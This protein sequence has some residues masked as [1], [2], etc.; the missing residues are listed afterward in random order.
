[1]Y[2]GSGHGHSSSSF[3]ASKLQN[4]FTTLLLA[5]FVFVSVSAFAQ[6][7]IE[8]AVG[9]TVYDQ[10]DAVVAGATVVVHNNGTNAEFKQTTN[11]S[12]YFRVT[13]LT[14]TTYTVTVTAPGFSSYKAQAVTVEV[15]RVTE[16]SPKLGV[17][18]TAEQIVVTGEAP[19]VN[20][21]SA[22]FA[23]VLNS[24]AI[25]NLP[26]NGGRWSDFA[27][28]TPGVNNNV[29]GFGLLNVRGISSLM[30]NNTIDG[31]NNNQAFFSEER[32]RT[33]AG[34]STPKVAVQEFQVNTSNYSAEYGRAAGGVINTVTKS[35]TNDIHGEA[36]F[37]YRDNA[38]GSTNPFVTLTAQNSSGA[39]VTT[40]Y[41]PS[42]IRRISG[43]GIGGAIIKD[44]LF[45][46]F[47]YDWFYRNF[48]GTGSASNPGAFFAAPSTA[49]IALLA[50]KLGVT[51]AQAQVDYTNGLNGLNS[52][53]GPVPRTGE[54]YIWFPKVD[55]VINDKN[56]ASFSVNRMRWASPAGIQTQAVNFYG[57][58]SFGSD[59][60]KDTWGIAN[61]NTVITSN[62]SNQF[63]FQYGLDFEYEYAQN[64]STYEQN[65]LVTPPGY[66]NPLGLPPQVTITNGF[67]FGVQTFLQRPQYPSEYIQQ[68]ADTVSWLKGKHSFK[69]GVDINHSLDQTQNLRTQYGSYSYAN[70]NS[71]QTAL[72][73]YFTDLYMHN[74]CGTKAHPAPCYSGTYQQAF[75]PAGLQFSTN[76]L[77]FFAEDTWKT[78]PRLTLTLGLRYEYEMMPSTPLA[79]SAVPATSQLPND[80]NNW[81]PRF[82]FAYD[83]FGDGNTSL[84]GGFGMYYG[85]IINSTIYSALIS[86]GNP[87]GQLTYFYPASA[88]PVFPQIL[89]APS[90]NVSP[91]MVYFNHGFQNPLVYE[92]DLS[93]QHE[94]G[95]GYVFSLN[96]LGSMGRELPDFVDTNLPTPTTITYTV[97]SASGQG[98]L[99]PGSQITSLFYTGARPNTSYGAMTDIFSGVNSSYN[100]LAAVLNKRFNNGVQFN[101]NYTW[102]HALDY[103]QN[104]TTGSDTNDLLVPNCMRCEYGNSNFDVRQR[105]IVS[106]VYDLP[107][108]VNGWAG[109]LAN[110]WELA[111]IY[112]AQS[113]LPYSLVT[114]GTPSCPAGFN[115]CGIGLTSAVSGVGSGIN[116]SGGASRIL[117]TGR[118]TFRYPRT[119]VVDLRIS[120][121]IPIKERYQLQIL[122]EAF[123]LANHVNVTGV[124]NLGYSIGTTAGVPT[125]T[126]NS[127][128][129]AVTSANSNFAYSTRNIQIG[130]KFTF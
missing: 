17:A 3:S 61:L 100:A 50:S 71:T 82:G 21:T 25:E 126:Y 24:V 94:F 13:G 88:G 81:G 64:P 112:Q 7:T 79:N 42:D 60:V 54:Q 38:W 11:D 78:T 124:Q 70:T 27:L 22:D 12:G 102:A 33:R 105:L 80:K 115:P 125:L 16:L 23:P 2:L 101:V 37:F 57:T 67:N 89:T 29:S 45:F 32:G 14:P 83:V 28:L 66:T 18:G 96:Y 35:G 121:S 122:G 59:Y 6:S 65:N 129:Q 119:Q 108:K 107:F 75:G 1:M 74:G 56:H 109:Y 128:F 92:T 98:P 127:P 52:M 110:G 90:G 97:A 36:Y 120:K 93:I 68:Y 63:R 87:N 10:H 95:K 9:G 46:Y 118:N 103:G 84:R 76:D 77:G 4:L 19:E 114:S 111:P 5:A 72:I 44:K 20:T 15:G 53:L 39:Y 130:A 41:K 49:S 117:Q 26:I 104:E 99:T 116:G 58:N 40:P 106:G 85:R 91:N 69:F 55:W 43:I 31:A 8:G 34:Y 113:G 73:N 47:A 30:N 51:P 123:N 48:P 86:T 62:L